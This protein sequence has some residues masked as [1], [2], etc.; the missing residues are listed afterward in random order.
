MPKSSRS[1]HHPRGEASNDGPRPTWSGTLS[2]G[3]VTIPVELY[4]AARQPSL[5][6]HTVTEDG[7]RLARRY[8][9]PDDDRDLESDDLVRG[10]EVNGKW[11]TV[12]DE[13]LEAL[14]PKKSR[15]IELKL[16]T[17]RANLHPA[18]FE[19][20]YVLAPARDNTASKAYQLLVSVMHQ[21]DRA[22]VATFVLREREYI[23][24]IISDGRLLLGETLRFAD[25]IRSA[26][27]VQLPAPGTFDP[28][29]VQRFTR[30]LEAKG[31]GRFDATKLVDPGHEKLAKL[32]EQKRKKGQVVTP[33]EPDEV[34]SA[35]AE[36]GEV[37]DLMRL[38]KQS[39]QAGKGSKARASR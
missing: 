22:G 21:Q 14:A 39:L 12:D 13:E 15:E 11:V 38:L 27:D 28:K 16:F 24:A 3:L 32:L 19:N 17:A 23:I 9:C 7:T 29:L 6:A 18:L 26:K 25:E 37:V 5:R 8:Y 20:P 10:A 36:G 31:K 1:H 4:S 34:A 33:P 2:F 35:A 30:A